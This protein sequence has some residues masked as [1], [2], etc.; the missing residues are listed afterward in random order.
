MW[1]SRLK[2]RLSK[3][4][5]VRSRQISDHQK[6]QI[7]ITHEKQAGWKRDSLTTVSGLLDST[8]KVV[9]Q[10]VTLIQAL[11]HCRWFLS[12]ETVEKVEKKTDVWVHVLWIIWIVVGLHSQ[13]AFRVCKYIIMLNC[14]LKWSLNFHSC[15]S[16]LCVLIQNS[17]CLYYSTCSYS[18]NI[19][20]F[21]PDEL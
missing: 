13:T 12:G 5:K 16:S 7:I 2:Q 8:S 21:P 9:C 3:K 19:P 20:W 6:H 11:A 17:Y 14:P 4:S 1:E 15:M 10:R 18:D